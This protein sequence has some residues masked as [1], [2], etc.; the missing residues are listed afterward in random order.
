MADNYP[1]E[2]VGRET[3]RPW[4]I[5]NKKDKVLICTASFYKNKLYVKIPRLGDCLHGDGGLRVGEVSQRSGV[6]HLII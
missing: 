6:T 5:P 1:R 2:C 3:D 4:N